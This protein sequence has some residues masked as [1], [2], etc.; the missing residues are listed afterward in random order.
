[1]KIVGP[2][3]ELDFFS[4]NDEVKCTFRAPH[5][6]DKALKD[7]DN[8]GYNTIAMKSP[9]FANGTTIPNGSYKF[10]LRALKVTGDP[11]QEEDFESWLSPIIGIV[12]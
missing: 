12:A 5:F 1:M 3:A 10:L 8:F 6:A 7:P 11:K 9:V 2:L 4:R